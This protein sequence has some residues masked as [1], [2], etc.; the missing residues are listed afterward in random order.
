ME[1]KTRE[2]YEKSEEPLLCKKIM[3]FAEQLLSQENVVMTNAQR[4]SLLSHI[5]AMVYRSKHNEKIQPV[6]TFLFQ[7][8]SE[9]SINM[10]NKIC[11]ILP[12]LHKDEKYLLSIHFESAR[13]ND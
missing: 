13:L 8:V 2:L 7:E 9:G 1:L 4:L 11:E 5:S 3:N 6:D 10:A 12:D